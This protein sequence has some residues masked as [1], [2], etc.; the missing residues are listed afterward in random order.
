M[1]YFKILNDVI[2]NKKIL[3]IL[4]ILILLTVLLVNKTIYEFRI[5]QELI[6][7]TFILIV[8]KLFIINLFMSKIKCPIKT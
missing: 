3:N 2:N 6:L 8:L 1:N 7:K 4:K 5:N